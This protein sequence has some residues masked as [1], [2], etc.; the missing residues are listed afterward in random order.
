MQQYIQ[1]QLDTGVSTLTVAKMAEVN[2]S[3]IRY[4]IK[5]GKLRR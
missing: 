1:S 3:T 2:E 5:E 4:W